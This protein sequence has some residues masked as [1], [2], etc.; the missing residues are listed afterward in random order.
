M[1]K[2]DFS[3]GIALRTMFSKVWLNNTILM[4]RKPRGL[5]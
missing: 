1:V 3:G 5:F 2:H 4:L